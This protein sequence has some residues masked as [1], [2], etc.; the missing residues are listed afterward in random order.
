MRL[1]RSVT[2]AISK[3]K[4]S[5]GNSS[6]DTWKESDPAEFR[7]PPVL[8]SNVGLRGTSGDPSNGI[9]TTRPAKRTPPTAALPTDIEAKTVAL[10]GSTPV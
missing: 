9:L 5:F 8:L 7:K 4:R 3:R 1:V 10:L 2:L 6:V